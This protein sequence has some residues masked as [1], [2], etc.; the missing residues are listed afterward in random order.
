[1]SDCV[2]CKIRDG[3]IPAKMVYED[4][5]VVAFEDVNPQAPTHTLVIPRKHIATANELGAEDSALV[6][7]LHWGCRE[8]WAPLMHGGQLHCDPH[9]F[10]HSCG[11]RRDQLIISIF[12]PGVSLYAS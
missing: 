1:M 4:D 2:F 10:R 6:G 3:E 9:W 11:L 7:K 5:Q 8:S 12:P